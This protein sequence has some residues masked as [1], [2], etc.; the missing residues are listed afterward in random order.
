MNQ[1]NQINFDQFFQ[2]PALDFLHRAIRSALDEDGPD[3][4]ADAVFSPKAP[5]RAQIVAKEPTLVA[6]LPIARLVLEETSRR[7]PGLWSLTCAARDGDAVSPGTEVCRLEGSVRILLRAERIILNFL[8]HMSGIANLTQ[9]YVQALEGTGVRLLDTRKTLPGLRYPE[10][11]AVRVGGGCN[12]RLNLY[13][14]LM[15]K[16]NHIDA[17]GGV[18]AAVAALAGAYDPMPPVEVE[19]RT[20]AEVREA[21][22]CK[23]SR[24]MLD[25]MDADLEAASLE[26]IPQGIEVEISG[27]VTLE[28]IRARACPASKRKPDF[29]SVGRLTHSAPSAD[30]SMR[31]GAC[32]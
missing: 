25:N 14:M 29:I 12:H 6:G 5:M 30:F 32:P 9:R 22:Q 16:D 28:T 7:A 19:C 23:V 1:T 4:T 3:L 27:N 31:I 10:K 18:R 17:A 13:E 24:I 8:T 11:Y 20:L 26:C 21:V 15:L 2:G